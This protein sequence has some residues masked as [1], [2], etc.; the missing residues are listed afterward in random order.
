ME[1][2]LK[3]EVIGN[4]NQEGVLVEIEKSMESV[5]TDIQSNVCSIYQ[6]LNIIHPDEVVHTEPNGFVDKVKIHC[7]DLGNINKALEIINVRLTKLVGDL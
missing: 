1:E 7:Y 6:K 4:V 5:I 2:N 3:T